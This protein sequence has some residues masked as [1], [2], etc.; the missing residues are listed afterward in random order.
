MTPVFT[1]DPDGAWSPSALARGPFDGLQGGG[2]AALMA[3]AIEAE[4]QGFVASLTT[5]FLRPVPVAPLQVVVRPLRTGRRV[6][7]L[8]A[9]LSAGGT[10]VAV[11][12]ATVIAELAASDLPT[13]ADRPADPTAFP[14]ERRA[15][16]HGG[17]WMMDTLDA[18][19]GDGIAWF[20]HERPLFDHPSALARVLVAADWAHGMFPPMGAQ[21]RPPAAIPNTD[22]SVHLFRPPGGEWIGIDAQTAWSQ[23]A[24]GAGWAAVFD[25]QGLIGRVAMSVAVTPLPLEAVA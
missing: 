16:M 20:R 25:A 24:I 15:A 11:Q 14:R 8:D 6:S 19:F 1:R 18:R 3:V 17:P 12:R 10:L 13:P 9:E 7:V 4:A 5:H 23:A 22:L 2:V 21:V